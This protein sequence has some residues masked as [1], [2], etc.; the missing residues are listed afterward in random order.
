MKKLNVKWALLI[1]MLTFMAACLFS[2]KIQREVSANEEIPVEDITPYKTPTGDV[3]KFLGIWMTS[4]YNLQPQPNNYTVVDSS[5]TL[6]TDQGRSWLSALTSGL[7][8]AHYQWYETTDG[9]KWTEISKKNGGTKKNL[10]VTPKEI[11]TKYYQQ[12]VKWYYIFSSLSPTVYSKVAAVHALDKHVSATDV[13]VSVDDDYIYNYD[14]EITTTSTYAH[15]KVTP[16]NFTGDIK[17]SIDNTDLATIDEES[18]LITANTRTKSGVVTVTATAI[19]NDGTKVSGSAE[20]TVGGGLEDQTVKAGETAKFE[21]M[22]NIGE[23]DEQED[24]NYSIRWFKEDPITHEQSEIEVG[25]NATSHTTPKTTLNDDGT[26]FFA[27]ITVKANNKTY[28]YTTNEATLHVIPDG[29]PD[30]T[31][32]DTLENKTYSNTS[33]NSTNLYDVN[34]DDE[35]VFKTDIVNNSSSGQLKNAS[36]N[37]PLRAGTTIN[38]VTLD[39]QEISDTDYEVKTNSDT[40]ELTLVVKNINLGIHKTASLVVDTKV[41][42]VNKRETYRTIGY[43]VGKDDSGNDVQKISAPRSLNLTT[44]KLE[45]TIK[46]IDYGSIKPIGNDQVIFR[47]NNESNWPD[48]VMDVDDMRRDKTP[49]TL[50][51]SQDSDFV[52]EDSKST[53]AGHLKFFDDDYEQDLLTGSAIVSQTKSGQEMTSLSWQAD[54]G[55]PLELDN[56]QLNAS[57]NYET[58]LNWV[59]TDSI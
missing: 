21:L 38:K 20:V 28:E 59:F 50:S 11:G 49:I 29:G 46:D 2:D 48:N 55:I 22:G 15:A 5:T 54:K 26:L 31:L 30:I 32:D 27:Y 9:K 47:Q 40:N 12:E 37:L 45:Y 56:K 3:R 19:N 18:G 16:T 42:D 10:T 43:L 14:S 25:N 33:D 35:V 13:E 53:L 24:M 36:Y 6:R 41:S 4:G 7:A 57:G 58:K 44:N 51:V 39:D 34:R 52:S 1:A 17:W 23:F 8:P